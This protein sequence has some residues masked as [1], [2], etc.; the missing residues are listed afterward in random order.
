MHR[1]RG[2]VDDEGAVAGEGIA[3][4]DGRE[5]EGGVVACGVFDGGAVEGEGGGG[6][7]VEVGGGV[8]VPVLC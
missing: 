5:R 7:V 6:F 3:A 1:R 8:A 4:V 2:G